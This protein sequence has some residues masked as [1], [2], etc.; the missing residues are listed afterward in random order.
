MT[1]GDQVKRK[2]FTYLA[3]VIITLAA[4]AATSVVHAAEW[5]WVNDYASFQNWNGSTLG[6]P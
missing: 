4:V 6:S 2:A 5:D 1:K 3:S